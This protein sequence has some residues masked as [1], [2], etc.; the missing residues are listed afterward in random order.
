MIAVAAPIAVTWR[1]RSR[2]STNHDGQRAGRRQQRVRERE[3]ARAAG[4]EPAAAVEAEPAEPQQA[5]AE[6]HVDG[7]VGQ[8]RLAPV[9]LARADDESRRPAPRSPSPSR[10][11]TPPAKSSVPC[12]LQ[13]AAAERPVR[14]H[15]VDEHRPQRGEDEERPEA[16]PLDDRAR[17][18]RRG[19]DAER[20]L[21]GEEEQLGD[22]RPVARREADVVTGTRGRGR[23]SSRRSPSKASE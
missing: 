11:G 19:D 15:G 18:Q 12:V 8:Q 23:R 5:G 6:Q 9:V 20:R 2:S 4:R 14:E 10:P 3:H 7:V 1:P 13:P 16:H 22:R 17:D 21:E